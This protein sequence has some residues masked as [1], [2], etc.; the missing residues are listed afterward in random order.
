MDKVFDEVVNRKISELL[1]VQKKRYDF[2]GK[3]NIWVGFV[4][5]VGRVRAN[6]HI[7]NC[8]LVKLSVIDGVNAVINISC[9][10]GHLIIPEVL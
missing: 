3:K 4:F 8:G 7:F 2:F 5:R 10:R 9:E 6:K 1:E